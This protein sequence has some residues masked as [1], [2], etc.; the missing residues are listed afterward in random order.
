[1]GLLSLQWVLVSLGG[2]QISG[3]HAEE[4]KH[5]RPFWALAERAATND[6]HS[7]LTVYF[8]QPAVQSVLAA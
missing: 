8:R 4:V 2:D 3:R 5:H 1:M 6:L 7:L